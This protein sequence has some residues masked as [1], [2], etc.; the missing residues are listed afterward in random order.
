[1]H[2][3]EIHTPGTELKLTDFSSPRAKWV[4]EDMLASLK[5]HFF[6]ATLALHLFEQSRQI[7]DPD[8]TLEQ[9]QRRLD[10]LT[11]LENNIN[12]ELDRSP[13]APNLATA[14]VMLKREQW[15]SGYLPEDLE[16]RIPFLHAKSFIS[17]LDSF[18]R[19]LLVIA[20][21]EGAPNL[22]EI[23]LKLQHAL[24]QLRK[25]RNSVQHSEDTIRELHGQ[26]KNKKRIILQPISAEFAP[27][28]LPTLIT[29]QLNSSSFGTTVSDGNYVEIEIGASTLK[30]L[31]NVLQE[32]LDSF[33]W[34]GPAGHSPGYAKLSRLYK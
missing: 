15:K 13:A 3:L 34:S 8:P 31:Q 21:S 16:R 2:I 30:I 20:E 4:M 32:V 9:F 19:L 25:I 7:S 14:E 11:E 17:A 1:M 24:P 33:S 5:R 29:E 18:D 12:L 6:D 10:R 28:E 26:G 27:P 22:N 23:Y